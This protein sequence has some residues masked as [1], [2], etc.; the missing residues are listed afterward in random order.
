[1]PKPLKIGLRDL[2]RLRVIALLE[3]R[4]AHA[5]ASDLASEVSIGPARQVAKVLTKSLKTKDSTLRLLARNFTNS[6]KPSK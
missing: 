6:V 2:S 1:M 4:G 5:L 3:L